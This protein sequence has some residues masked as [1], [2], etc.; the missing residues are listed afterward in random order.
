MRFRCPLRPPPSP[1]RAG[2]REYASSTRR[3]CWIWSNLM[4][5]YWSR[6]ATGL[7]TRLPRGSREL[8]QL[9]AP[10]RLASSKYTTGSGILSSN[11]EDRKGKGWRVCA[12]GKQ[13]GR[14]D[15]LS[16]ISHLSQNMA[17]HQRYR[18]ASH[19]CVPRLRQN[20]E[21]T[22]AVKGDKMQLT[23][24]HVHSPRHGQL[25]QVAVVLADTDK[26]HRD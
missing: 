7:R 23:H 16:V 5:F 20:C 6:A 8:E 14:V 24:Q 19:G 1:R 18:S 15:D 12:S 26:L 3:K 17:W 22:T 10:T 13:K 9:E 25:S 21:P 11:L 4:D 2:S